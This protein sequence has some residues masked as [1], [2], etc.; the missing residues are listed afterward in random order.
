MGGGGCNWVAG[1]REHICG[2]RDVGVYALKVS[3]GVCVSVYRGKG[4]GF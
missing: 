2:V 4:V 3:V 1:G